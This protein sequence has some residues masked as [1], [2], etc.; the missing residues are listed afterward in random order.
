[1]KQSPVIKAIATYIPDTVVDNQDITNK[2]NYD[3]PL[4]SYGALGRLLGSNTRHFADSETQVSDLACLA[5]NKLLSHHSTT[6][7]DLLIFAAASSD[8]IEPATANIIQ[9]KLGL[10]CPVMDIKNACNS[11]VTAIQTASAFV[12]AGYYRNVLIVNGEKLSEVVNYNPRDNEHFTRCLASYSL[13]DAGAAIL[14]GCGEG[15]KIVYQKFSSLGEYWDLC[16]VKGGGSMAFRDSNEYYFESNSR[17][18]KDVFTSLA[19]AFISECLKEAGWKTEDINCVVSHQISGTTINH[20][21]EVLNIPLAKC[22][23]TFSLYGNT[24]AATIPLAIDYALKE[25]KLI[26]GDK[27]LIFGMAAGISLSVQLIEW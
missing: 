14:I 3:N 17:M 1:M 9:L 22:V 2:I 7:I 16:T 6:H 8:L 10:N 19:P 20:L 4:L 15:S 11:I 23:N 26:K 18:L 12:E 13:G 24:A 5:A 21:A 27:L 25:N